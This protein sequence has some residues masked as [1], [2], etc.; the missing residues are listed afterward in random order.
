MAP[1]STESARYAAGLSIADFEDALQAAAA[2]A[3]NADT[4]ATRNIRH[5]RQS[6]V[7]AQ[8]PSILVSALF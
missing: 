7:K 4:I 2:V 8:T 6:P 5:Y 1:T 3:C